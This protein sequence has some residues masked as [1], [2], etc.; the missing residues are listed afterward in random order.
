MNDLALYQVTRTSA[1]NRESNRMTD[2][3]N[4]LLTLGD[5]LFRS[6]LFPVAVSQVWGSGGEISAVIPGATSALC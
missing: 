5:V 6:Q 4:T 2:A 3:D 1:A